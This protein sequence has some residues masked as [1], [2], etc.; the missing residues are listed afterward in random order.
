M[1]LGT[2]GQSKNRETGT[3]PAPRDCATAGRNLCATRMLKASARVSQCWGNSA[4]RGSP[5]LPPEMPAYTFR[6]GLGHS[7]GHIARATECASV[8]DVRRTITCN[9]PTWCAAQR[10]GVF[11]DVC[12]QHRHPSESTVTTAPRNTKPI[13]CYAS[14]SPSFPHPHPQP[15]P[16]QPGIYLV[17]LHYRTLGSPGN[18]ILYHGILRDW[19]FLL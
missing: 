10:L 6:T 5:S 16:Q 8:P 18:G 3:L 11:M 1:T 9:S 14:G 13:S 12:R 7:C 2:R 17:S 15:S 4:A 19:L